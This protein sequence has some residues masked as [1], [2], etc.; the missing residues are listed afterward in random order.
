MKS[1]RRW[2]VP[3]NNHLR[4]SGEYELDSKWNKYLSR[5]SAGRCGSAETFGHFIK[6]LWYFQSIVLF[7]G[8]HNSSADW[9]QQ[10]TQRIDGER[11]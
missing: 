6:F 4:L 9:N 3:W 1:I 11:R 5:S 8:G 2:P 7:E 10:S